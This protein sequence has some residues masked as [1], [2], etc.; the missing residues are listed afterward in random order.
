ML[1]ALLAAVRLLPAVATFGTGANTFIS[2]YPTLASVFDSLVGAP[3]RD[4]LL[5]QWELDAHVGAAGFFLLCLGALPFREVSTRFLNA[6]LLPSAILIVLSFG[7]I[8]GQTL[9]RLSGFVS[10]RV[11]T[12]LLILPV[13]SL[14]LAA[15]VRMD[16]WWRRA[17]VSHAT[18]I[19]VLAG[20]WWLAL[21]LLLHAQAWRPHA[22]L[23]TNVLPAE[24]LKI[25]PV[26]PAY[27]WAFWIGAAVARDG[28]RGRRVAAPA[29]T[30]AR[31]RS[32]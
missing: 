32:C 30:A 25:M 23:S 29:I 7:N 8:Y 21:T 28:D 10:K 16:G 11:T 2:G 22:G 20:A 9:F 26:E 31:R 1:T 27:F 17:R 15:A 5:D 19:P 12:R 6:L 3:V 24:V 13:L 4:A 18:A 14:T